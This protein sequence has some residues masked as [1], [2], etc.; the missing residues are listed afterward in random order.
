MKTGE[1]T[2]KDVGRAVEVMALAPAESR[3]GKAVWVEAELLAV[4]TATLY[5]RF[6]EA[7]LGRVNA[8][9]QRGAPKVRATFTVPPVCARWPNGGA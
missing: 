9:V 7:A 4:S 1:A 8:L 3:S 2:P 5:V 6:T